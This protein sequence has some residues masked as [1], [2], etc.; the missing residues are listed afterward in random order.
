MAMAELSI[1][2]PVER[3]DLGAFVAHAVRLDRNVGTHA[4]AEMVRV[5]ATGS[6]LWLEARYGAVL[7]HRHALQLLLV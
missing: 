1:P 3:D 2:D 7:R 6:W 4:A 5:S